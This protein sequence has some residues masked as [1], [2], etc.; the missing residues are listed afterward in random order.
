MFPSPAL[1]QM[2]LRLAILAVLRLEPQSLGL[3]APVCSSMGWLV[4][5][6]TKRSFVCPL[7]D[8]SVDFVAGGNLLA[9]RPLSMV[10]ESIIFLITYWRVVF[11]MYYFITSLVFDSLFFSPRSI[12]ICWL[13]VALGHVFIL[14]QPRGSHFRHFPQWRFFCKYIAVDSW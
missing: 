5:S 3:L 11:N 4:S 2:H 14:E 10:S 7:G 8:P 12:I 6:L 13:L 1:L 9:L